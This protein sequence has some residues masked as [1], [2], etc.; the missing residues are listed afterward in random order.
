MGSKN[1]EI[2]ISCQRNS[3]TL[4]QEF[5]HFVRIR[6]VTD[7]VTKAEKFVGSNAI[8]VGENCLQREEVGVWVGD[9]A[10]DHPR[11]IARAKPGRRYSGLGDARPAP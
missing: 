8:D 3:A 4:L 11:N 9:D 2:V 7:K 5:N 1:S 6:P 10:E